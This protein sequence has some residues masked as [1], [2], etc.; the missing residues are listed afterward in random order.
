MRWDRNDTRQIETE[1]M[2]NEYLETFINKVFGKQLSEN[3]P[4]WLHEL[5]VHC[6]VIIL[7]VDPAAG[8]RDYGLPLGDVARDDAAALLV[9]LVDSKFEDVLTLLDAELLVDLVLDGEAVAVPAE[10][11]RDV[12][13]GHGV[14]ARDNV[15]DCAS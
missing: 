6:L 8:A 12:M 7:E 13:A 15:L 9:V 4:H 14:V 3:P 11:A 5:E 10:A 2:C 1:T